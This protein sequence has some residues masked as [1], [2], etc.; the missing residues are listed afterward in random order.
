MYF[1]GAQ[2]AFPACLAVMSDVP[3]PLSVIVIPD[4]VATCWLRLEKVN[5]SPLEAVP[6][7]VTGDSLYFFVNDCVQ[8]IVC[9]FRETRI[10]VNVARNPPLDPVT[11]PAVYAT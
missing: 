8:F 7:S 5:P 9:D 6:D 1:A 10:S 3:I 11:L 2:V 4:I